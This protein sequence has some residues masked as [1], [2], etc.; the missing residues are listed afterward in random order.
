MKPRFEEYIE[1]YGAQLICPNCGE[2]YLH[3]G[4]VEVFDRTEDANAGIHATVWDGTM[5]VSTDMDGNPSDRRHGVN[6]YFTCELC[7]KRTLLTIAQHKG[8]T[9]LN[10]LIL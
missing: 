6:I 3:H 4:A 8:N 7:D 1:G 2:N 5:Q 9:Y 10:S